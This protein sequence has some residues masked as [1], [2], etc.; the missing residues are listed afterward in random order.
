MGGTTQPKTFP[1]LSS[2]LFLGGVGTL[3]ATSTHGRQQFVQV[4]PAKPL[5]SLETRW[6]A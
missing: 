6:R 2:R 1:T 3:K 4:F 5:P